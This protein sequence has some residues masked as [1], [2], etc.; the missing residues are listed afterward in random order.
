MSDL[1]IKFNVDLDKK[2]DYENGYFL[3]CDTSRIGKFINQLKIYEQIV[4]L[5]GD[6]LEFGVYKGASIVRLLSFRDLLETPASRRIFGF[7]AFGEFPNELEKEADRDFVKKFEDEGGLGISK[8][9]LEKLLK[10][11]GIVNY[12]L[13]EGDINATLPSFIESHPELRVSLL[14]I[15]VDVYEPSKLILELLW[16]RIVQGGIIML[17]DYGTVMG[18]TLAVEECFKGK[19]VK[20]SKFPYYKVPSYIVKSI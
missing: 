2:W 10:L 13:I 7:D 11:K 3:T 4:D 16:D 17:D 18:E 20:L 8:V 5:P 12:E 19:K 6:I 14:H 9:D 15:D 1:N